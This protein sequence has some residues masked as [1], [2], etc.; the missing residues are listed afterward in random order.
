MNLESL[1]QLP[2]DRKFYLVIGVE[3]DKYDYVF[4]TGKYKMYFIDSGVKVEKMSRLQ[5]LSEPVG[6]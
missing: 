4:D 5:V 2:K 3:P 6:E 1:N